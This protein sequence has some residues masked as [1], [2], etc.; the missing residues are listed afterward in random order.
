MSSSMSEE[1]SARPMSVLG[2]ETLPTSSSS[3]S[4]VVLLL[5]A[6]ALGE[7]RAAFP[8][9]PGAARPCFLSSDLRAG[10]SADTG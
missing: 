7:L 5:S 3:T 1:R 9:A 6:L 4:T 2:W 8:L 10:S